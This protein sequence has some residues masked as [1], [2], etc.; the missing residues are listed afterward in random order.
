[1]SLDLHV[2]ILLPFYIFF[3]MHLFV[4]KLVYAYENVCMVIF[5]CPKLEKDEGLKIEKIVLGGGKAV[6]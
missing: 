3:F 2:P 6:I 5:F 4:S 1:M